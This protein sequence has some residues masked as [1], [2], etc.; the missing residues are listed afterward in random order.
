MNVAERDE[1]ISGTAEERRREG[2]AVALG[3]RVLN[4]PCRV[5]AGFIRTDAVW[6]PPLRPC[7][8]LCLP[9]LVSDIT[10]PLLLA[11]AVCFPSQCRHRGHRLSHCT[12][13]TFTWASSYLVIH[14]TKSIGIETGIVQ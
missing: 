1:G 7:G 8:L 2:D 10:G 13:I 14:N 6:V 4:D 9:A 3:A 5:P 12:R 11:L